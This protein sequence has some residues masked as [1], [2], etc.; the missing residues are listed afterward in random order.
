[1]LTYYFPPCAASGTYR[2]LGFARY[3]PRN[4]WNVSVVAPPTVKWEPTD[5]GLVQN[6]PADTRITH[7]PFP[8][9]FA[10]RYR[11]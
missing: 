5:P 4:G 7:V 9:T 6:V 3:L 10:A 8:D 2:A 1:M 11:K